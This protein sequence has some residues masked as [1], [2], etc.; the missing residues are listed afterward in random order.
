MGWVYKG[1]AYM[2]VTTDIENLQKELDLMYEWQNENNMR[3]NGSKFQVVN[4]WNNDELKM[5]GIYR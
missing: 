4:I 5:C 2:W 3:Y 1:W